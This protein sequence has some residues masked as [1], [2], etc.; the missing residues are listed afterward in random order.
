MWVRGS[1]TW[2]SQQRR[3]IHIESSWFMKS[4]ELMYLWVSWLIYMR[5]TTEAPQSYIKFVTHNEFV[6]HLLV[7][8]VTHLNLFTWEAQQRCLIHMESSWLV[9]ISRPVSKSSCEHRDS[10]TWEL[11]QRR[12]IHIESSW[13]ITSLWLI[14]IW[15]RGSFTWQSQQRRL[16]HVESSWLIKSWW[17]IY[18]WVSWLVLFYLHERHNRDASFIYRVCDT[19]F[20][21]QIVTH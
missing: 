4:W 1:F 19:E 10:F 13:L 8:I 2:Q 6:T 18:L 15:V 9:K 20:V 14:N 21:I 11:E 3:H 7:S 12:H 5:G 17:L 16:I